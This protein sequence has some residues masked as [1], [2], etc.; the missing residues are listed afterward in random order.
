V[1]HINDKMLR[2][3]GYQKRELIGQKVEVVFPPRE[4][5]VHKDSL[6]DLYTR[7]VFEH[8]LSDAYELSQKESQCSAL[9]FMDLDRFKSINDQWGHPMGDSVLMAIAQRMKQCI[10]PHDLLARL[11]GDEFGLILNNIQTVQN[12]EEI[13]A[14]FCKTIAKPLS[15]NDQSVSLSVSIGIVC[16]PTSIDKT[17]VMTYVDRAMYTVKRT[18]GNGW[19]YYH[20]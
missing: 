15:I 19:K 14:R 16:F 1:I 18:G 7:T 20:A 12:A 11:G 9:L 5:T 4:R 10:R 17:E 2:M 6:T 8:A 13:A 3:L